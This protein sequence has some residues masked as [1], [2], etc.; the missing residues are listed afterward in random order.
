MGTTSYLLVY[1]N[2]KGYLK[3][4]NCGIVKIVTA[5]LQGKPLT[6]KITE[7]IPVLTNVRFPVTINSVLQRRNAV[8]T[9]SKQV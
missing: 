2:K 3:T 1:K 8:N 9:D 6:L 5:P 4:A 7:K